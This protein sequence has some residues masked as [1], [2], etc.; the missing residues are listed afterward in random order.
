MTGEI[1]LT[2]CTAFVA[3]PASLLCGR[4]RKAPGQVSGDHDPFACVDCAR[5]RH[6][7]Q[8]ATRAA[9]RAIPRQ[10]GRS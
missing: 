10:G 8:A 5:M 6:P 4:L 9:L 3:L 7:S 2:A 1:L